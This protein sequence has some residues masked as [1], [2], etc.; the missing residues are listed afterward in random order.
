MYPYFWIHKQS[1]L[2]LLNN[3]NKNEQN[4]NLTFTLIIDQQIVI[5]IHG[6]KL[7]LFVKIFQRLNNHLFVVVFVKY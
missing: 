4:N 3:I 7:N 1:K 6:L 5:N 2:S